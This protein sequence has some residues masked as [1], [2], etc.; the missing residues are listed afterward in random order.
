MGGGLFGG[1]IGGLIGIVAFYNVCHG[2]PDGIAHDPQ[3]TIR[4]ESRANAEE[5]GDQI[6][7]PEIRDICTFFEHSSISIIIYK[8][9][10]FLHANAQASR[11]LLWS[12]DNDAFQLCSVRTDGPLQA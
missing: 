12:N 1:L 7:G 10:S 11:W 5:E 9:S 4:R 6:S 3:A 8:H 2:S